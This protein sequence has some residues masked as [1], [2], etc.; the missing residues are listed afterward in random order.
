MDFSEIKAAI[1]SAAKQFTAK[2]ATMVEYLANMVY[3]GEV[4][5]AADGIH[6]PFWLVKSGPMLRTLGPIALSGISQETPGL[7]TTTAAH[8]LSAGDMIAVWGVNGMTE[9]NGVSGTVLQTPSTTTFEMYESSDNDAALS[10]D[11]SGFSAYTSG[12]YVYHHGVRLPTMLDIDRVL[13]S[14]VIGASKPMEQKGVEQWV[15]EVDRKDSE[16][17]GTPTMFR[18]LRRYKEDGTTFDQIIWYP[19]PD[20]VHKIR[21]KFKELPAKLSDDTDTPLLPHTFHDAIVAGVVARLTEGSGQVGVE[22]QSM[23]PTVYRLQL[24]AL[25]EYNEKYWSNIFNNQSVSHYLA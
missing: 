17:T 21:Y 15:D 24:E 18:H 16:V 10:V 23:W 7:F 20:G 11:T 14:S 25:R 6:P 1:A 19:Y 12:G 9:I 13:F 4:L 22:K 2:K 8:G 5:P 3:L